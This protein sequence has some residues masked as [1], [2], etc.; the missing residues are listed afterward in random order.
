MQKSTFDGSM[1]QGEV[2][3]PNGFILSSCECPLTS[4]FFAG[5]FSFLLFTSPWTAAAYTSLTLTLGKQASRPC[6][7]CHKCHSVN[8]PLGHAHVQCNLFPPP[9][10]PASPS[11][12]LELEPSLGESVVRRLGSWELVS[13]K[14]LF[15]RYTDYRMKFPTWKLCQLRSNSPD[16]INLSNLQNDLFMENSL[17]CLF[18]HIEYNAFQEHLH[19]ISSFSFTCS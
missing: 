19:L 16:G 5:C 12:R 11:S 10:P 18:G 15:S 1:F 8:Q 3:G 13:R 17:T 4:A 14:P 9:W 6:Y 7:Y 2:Y